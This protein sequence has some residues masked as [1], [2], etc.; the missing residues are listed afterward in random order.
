MDW[1]MNADRNE[2]AKHHGILFYQ[3][4]ALDME[5]WGL[6]L[7]GRIAFF[8]TDSYDERLYAYED[9]VYYT[10]TIG[11]YYYQGIRG[12]LVLHYKYKC[13]HCWLRLSRTHYLNRTS[14]GSGLNEI[15]APH[16]T[17]L[18]AQIMFNF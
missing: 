9:D 8:N 1:L 17:E 15:K 10:F 5:H 6:S 18:R 12:Y 13:F 3:D 14:I 7:H 11:S 2:S 4:I 16:K